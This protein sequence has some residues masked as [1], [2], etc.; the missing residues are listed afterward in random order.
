MTISS[1]EI[2]TG[3][4]AGIETLE[5]KEQVP[6]DEVTVDNSRDYRDPVH[7]SPATSSVA[8]SGA[9]PRSHGRREDAMDAASQEAASRPRGDLSQSPPPPG[10]E[11][12]VPPSAPHLT[13]PQVWAD[14][15]ADLAI[16]N[17]KS[18]R[19][20]IEENR[21]G[22]NLSEVMD[23]LERIDEERR[24]ITL[25][26]ISDTPLVQKGRLIDERA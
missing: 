10:A 6:S 19:Q 1:A 26:G 23:L 14:R 5:K 3:M 21:D 18:L 24:M 9:L 4:K 12:N 8:L 7:S 2:L 20:W 16:R 13:S 25:A 17:L 15:F 11:W 22:L